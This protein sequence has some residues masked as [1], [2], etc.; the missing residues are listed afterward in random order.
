MSVR[1]RFLST[2]VTVLLAAGLLTPGAAAEAGP[3]PGPTDVVKGF[4]LV[5]I[6]S[7]NCLRVVAGT[8]RAVQGPCRP[9]A[10]ALWRMRLATMDGLFQIQNLRSGGC[11][12]ASRGPAI[13]QFRCDD[14]PTRRWR[15]L[16]GAGD[17]FLMRS[18]VSGRCV[19]AAGAGAVVQG[20]CA[21]VPS[22]RW[23]GQAEGGNRP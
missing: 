10:S 9:D 20:T 4:L 22:R 12:T 16:D 14:A 23:H 3:P 8:G 5:N 11:L 6:G 2:A 15:L 21:D 1:R 13:V 17:T 18:V 19:T 7:R